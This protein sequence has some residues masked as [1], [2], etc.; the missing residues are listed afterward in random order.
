VK[1]AKLALA[2]RLAEFRDYR[3]LAPSDGIIERCLVNAGEYNQ[4]P[5]KPGFLLSVGQWFE[6]YFDQTTTGRFRPGEK[7]E[8]LLEAFPGTPIPAVVRSINPFVSY[9]VSGPE[10]TRP[11]R[12]SGSGAPEWASTF[13]V[14]I[15]LQSFDLP[16]AIGLTGFAKIQQTRVVMAIPTG[17]VLS[18][19]AGEGI[20]FAVEDGDFHPR[21]VS[22]GDASAGWTEILNGLDT[23]DVVIVDGHHVLQIGDSIRIVA[24][25]GSNSTDSSSTDFSSTDSSSTD[26]SSTDSS[27]TGSSPTES[28]SLMQASTEP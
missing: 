22:L 15:D 21:R 3:V 23:E 26:S 2:H 1:E 10:T 4:D 18:T 5:G 24:G 19:S 11:I 28:S 25:P 20:V 17:A 27:S 12:P 9:S 6:G 13:P 7:A 8:I 14:S 16:F